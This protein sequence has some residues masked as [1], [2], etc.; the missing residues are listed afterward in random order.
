VT[1]SSKGAKEKKKKQCRHPDWQTLTMGTSM[2]EHAST[3]SLF[4]VS[5]QEGVNVQRDVIV[6]VEDRKPRKAMFRREHR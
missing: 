4:G 3:S 5:E 6:S 1:V 2:D